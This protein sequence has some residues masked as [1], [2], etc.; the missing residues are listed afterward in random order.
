MSALVAARPKSRR[1]CRNGPNKQKSQK[2]SKIGD[3]SMPNHSNALHCSAVQYSIAVQCNPVQRIL[4]CSA[5]PSLRGARLEAERPAAFFLLPS[6]FFS[7]FLL[8][9]VYSLRCSPLIFPLFAGAIVITTP[10]LPLL[11]PPA[12]ARVRVPL[13]SPLPACGHRSSR[14]RRGGRSRR[15]AVRGRAS[16]AAGR[17]YASRATAM[18]DEEKEKAMRMRPG[19]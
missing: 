11:L 9:L 7:F 1:F 13:F 4:R 12:H 2:T 8:F 16:A 6:L 15:T 18:P 5:L 14:A 19:G 3:I 17:R 10:L